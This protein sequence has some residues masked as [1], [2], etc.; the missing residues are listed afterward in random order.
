[1]IEHWPHLLL[2][3]PRPIYDLALLFYDQS[4]HPLFAIGI[5]ELIRNEQIRPGQLSPGP[6]MFSVNPRIAEEY[7]RVIFVNKL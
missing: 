4:T 5:A 7:I 2:R 1:L 6:K 3:H